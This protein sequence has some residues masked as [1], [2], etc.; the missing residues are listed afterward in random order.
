MTDKTKLIVAGCALVVGAGLI[1]WN[2]RDP[3]RGF[4]E[5][6]KQEENVTLDQIP[7][8]VR[9]T[10]K[11]ESAGGVVEEIQKETKQGQV[12]YEADIIVGGQ[13]IDLEIAEDGS[14]LERKIKS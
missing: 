9:T 10:I 12:K 7:A 3:D 4:Y 5:Q 1:A 6:P 8:P 11:R 14:I 13:K 2:M